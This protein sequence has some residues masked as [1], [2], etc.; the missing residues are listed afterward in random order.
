MRLTIE[1]Q[2]FATHVGP[3]IVTMS[4]GIAGT[5]D[6]GGLSAEPL[7][8]EADLALNRARPTGLEESSTKRQSSDFGGLTQSYDLG[9]ACCIICRIA[10]FDPGARFS[11]HV[12]SRLQASSRL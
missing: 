7:I 8:H 5:D 6:W 11:R 12:S 2:P 9:R 3:L 1:S 4:L 10:E